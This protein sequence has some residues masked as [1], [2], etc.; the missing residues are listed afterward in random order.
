MTAKMVLLQ[1]TVPHPNARFVSFSVDPTHD[2]PET[3][4]QYAALWKGDESRWLLLSTDRKTLY[5]TAAGMKVAVLPTDD[6]DDGIL[7]SNLFFLVDQQ[8]RIR[9]VYS[10][11][12]D[13][14]MK[15]LALDAETLLGG[16]SYVS[17]DKSVTDEPPAQAGERLFN[18]FGC[19]ACHSQSNIAP[20][21][22]GLFGGSVS[23]NDGGKATVDDAYVREAILDPD[24]RIVAGY[25]Q[26]MP[27]YR[28]YLSDQQVDSLIAYLRSLRGG[29]TDERTNIRVAV[30]PQARPPTAIDPVCGMEVRVG[31]DMPHV[32]HQGNTYHFCSDHCREMFTRNPN[33]YASQHN[34]S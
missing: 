9:G 15:Q 21:L 32:E 30:S 23:L 26:L 10:S 27:S 1:K 7:H 2:T 8:S 12:E 33:K 18:S 25:L 28:E 29:P 16:G 31:D 6:Q 17:L 11:R 34:P 14:A 22:V 13:N 19:A 3:L 5:R 4:K 20:S 24:V